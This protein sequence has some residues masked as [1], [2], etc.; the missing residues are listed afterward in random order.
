MEK[1]WNPKRNNSLIELF[2]KKKVHKKNFLKGFF[3]KKVH[4]KTF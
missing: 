4:K 3:K 1:K 2:L